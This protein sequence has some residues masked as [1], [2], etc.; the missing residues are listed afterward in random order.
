MGMKTYVDSEFQ[1]TMI[2]QLLRTTFKNIDECEYDLLTDRIAE[3]LENMRKMRDTL[4]EKENASLTEAAEK[5]GVSYSAVLDSFVYFQL[6]VENVWL[7]R[8]LEIVQAA[9]DE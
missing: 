4:E 2:Q 3:K 6:I 8:Y 5:H 9:N 1:K 7:I